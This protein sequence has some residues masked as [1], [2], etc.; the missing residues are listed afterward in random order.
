MTQLSEWACFLLQPFV[1]FREQNLPSAGKSTPL[2]SALAIPTC[3]TPRPDGGG[4]ELCADFS[5]Q[6][7]R[8]R[9]L[10]GPLAP[11]WLPLAMFFVRCWP[12]LSW[13]RRLASPSSDGRPLLVEGLEIIC[14]TSR[15]ESLARA[16]HDGAHRNTR[17]S[18]RTRVYVSVARHVPLDASCSQ[19][20]GRASRRRL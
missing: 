16:T 10:R 19:A 12:C 5:L 14:K 6:C 3:L 1:M 9:C 18:Q 4:M 13:I 17:R 8:F 11:S 2:A 15:G 20:I 7:L